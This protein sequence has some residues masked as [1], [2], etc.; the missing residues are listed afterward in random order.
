MDDP[1]NKARLSEM[2]LTRSKAVV[3]TI[4]AICT[5]MLSYMEGDIAEIEFKDGDRIH[6]GEVVKV[7]IFP[8]AGMQVF[9][10]VAVVRSRNAIMVVV[11]PAKEEKFGEIGESLNLEL[12]C[13]GRLY[14]KCPDVPLPQVYTCRLKHISSNRIVFMVDKK[15]EI[16][17]SRV[18]VEFS[19]DIKLKCEA[20]IV[21]RSDEGKEICYVAVYE[22]LAEENAFSLKAYMLKRQIR[23][24]YGKKKFTAVYPRMNRTW[25]KSMVN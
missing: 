16:A 9:Y 23:K 14:A 10:S 21:S 4:D 7:T 19:S 24:Y 5:G 17:C 25:M 20:E 3:E 8:P 15:M 2:P 13:K 18:A 22:G 6:L 12:N 1:I 11:P